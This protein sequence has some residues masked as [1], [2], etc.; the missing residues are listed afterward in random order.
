MQIETRAIERQG[1]A[2]TNFDRTL[3]AAQSDLARESL[4]DPYKLDFLGLE[5]DAREREIE[6]ALVDHADVSGAVGL[7]T[8]GQLRRADRLRD[9]LAA[10]LS[11]SACG[12]K[13]CPGP[14]TSSACARP[15]AGGPPG[16]R[17]RPPA[18]PGPRRV[19]ARP[20]ARDPERSPRCPGPPHRGSSPPGART[21]QDWPPRTS[22][23][24]ATAS[25]AAG[26]ARHRYL[27]AQRVSGQAHLPR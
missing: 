3:P 18:R 16:C 24:P 20:A 1:K 11:V 15:P 25:R 2:V 19:P 23:W 12:T 10:R 27:E 21:A 5:E 8:D 6:Q 17:A 13:N 26:S 9:A 7:V 14:Y 22:S 4:K